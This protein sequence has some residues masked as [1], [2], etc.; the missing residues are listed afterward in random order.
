MRLGKQD[1]R[2]GAISGSDDDQSDTPAELEFKSI[3][4]IGDGG[5]GAWKDGVGRFPT[6]TTRTRRARK[7]HR[8]LWREVNVMVPW[9]Q[10]QPRMSLLSKRRR[11]ATLHGVGTS[12]SRDLNTVGSSGE[13]QPSILTIIWIANFSILLKIVCRRHSRAPSLISSEFLPLGKLCAILHKSIDSKTPRARL[14]TVE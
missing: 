11:Y 13:A 4:T 2:N 12:F 10:S 5:L 9:V 7:H 8:Q 14:P 3:K 1:Y 6:E